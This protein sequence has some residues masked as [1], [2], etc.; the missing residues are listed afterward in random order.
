M[1]IDVVVRTAKNSVKLQENET[2]SILLKSSL[3]PFISVCV[4]VG[5]GDGGN[6]GSVR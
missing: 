3:L 6:S 1:P 4:G 2:T 5:G